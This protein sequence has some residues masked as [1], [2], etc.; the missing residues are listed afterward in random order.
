MC[1]NDRSQSRGE[2][3]MQ[4]TNAGAAGATA[5]VDWLERHGVA[6]EIHEHATSFTAAETANAE[7]VDPAT[8]AKVVAVRT[9]DG[10][11]ALCVLDATD[12]LLLK[13][14]AA[15]L[16]IEQVTLLDEEDLEALAPQFEVGTLPPIPDL[17]GVPVYVD[18]AVRDDPK[19]S[20]AAGTHRRAVRVDRV[21][22]EEA[23]GV[24]YG[25][26]AARRPSWM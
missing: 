25:R 1:R 13:E 4:Q 16:G 14:L 21:A 23:A 20:F 12:Q 11:I 5:I 24:G 10:R 9:S 8:F 26:F 6:Y 17:V 2:Q 22:W 18:E 19:I 3:Q 7:G 15:E